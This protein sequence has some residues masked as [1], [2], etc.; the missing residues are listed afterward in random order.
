MSNYAGGGSASGS[1]S[2]SKETASSFNIEAVKRKVSNVSKTPASAQSTERF[3]KISENPFFK[4]M[5]EKSL[6]PEEKRDAMIKALIVDP[7]LS[8]EQNRVERAEHG[9]VGNWRVLRPSVR[10][11]GHE[12]VPDRLRGDD[13]AAH[14]YSGCGVRAASGR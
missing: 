4:I 9:F 3:A 1:L 13:E 7:E 2:R 10:V 11:E 14:G 5:S 6:S 12:H 8:K